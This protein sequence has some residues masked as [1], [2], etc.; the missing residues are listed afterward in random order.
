MDWQALT[1]RGI[2]RW[3]SALL[4]L[5]AFVSGIAQ[6][7]TVLV[8]GASGSSGDAFVAALTRNLGSRYA[9]STSAPASDVSLVVALHAGMLPAARELKRPVLAVLPDTDSTELRHGEGALYWSPS[10]TDQLRLARTIFPSLRRVGLLLDASTDAS[11]VR[12]LREQAARLQIDIQVRQAEPDLLVRQVAELAGTTDVLMAPVDS[13]LF[14]RDT[15]RA[16]L[17]AAYRQNRV[18]IGPN[19]AV[20]RAGALASLYV[21][22]EV[23]AAEVADRIRRQ[24]DEASWGLASRITRFDVVTNPQVARALGMHLPEAEQLTRLLRAEESVPWP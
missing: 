19:P 15:L 16:V 12:A 24:S 10:L 11:R 8:L 17:L 3:L 21:T 1:G 4:L 2:G 7:A 22:P 5:S 20:V 13:R 14:V 9:V 23:L 18:F 6:A